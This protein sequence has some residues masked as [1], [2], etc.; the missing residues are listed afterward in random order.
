MSDAPSSPLT[1]TPLERACCEIVA[2]LRDGAVSDDPM[3]MLG[4]PE[5]SL[6]A[7]TGEIAERFLARAGEAGFALEIVS[8]PTLDGPAYEPRW[9]H[10]GASF[11]GFKQPAPAQN[12]DEAR[13]LAC[14]ALLRNEWCR[15]R[16]R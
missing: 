7:R 16:L 1:Q 13:V 10:R 12:L 11:V 15:E 3:F 4:H 14:A 5:K 8:S 2:W 9:T 6:E